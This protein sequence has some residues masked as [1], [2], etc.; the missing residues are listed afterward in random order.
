MP[1]PR[2]LLPR[3]PTL[4]AHLRIHAL[5][6]MQPQGN[7]QRNRFSLGKPFTAA[8]IAGDVSSTRHV[9]PI[10]HD[11]M[12]VLLQPEQFG[13]NLQSRRPSRRWGNGSLS[14]PSSAL[15]VNLP[16]PFFDGAVLRTVPQG[17]SADFLSGIFPTAALYASSAAFC[18]ATSS[19]V[20]GRPEPPNMFKFC[21]LASAV[22]SSMIADATMM[23]LMVASPFLPLNNF[24]RFLFLAAQLFDHARC[25]QNG[26]IGGADVEPGLE[27]RDRR[28]HRQT[29][30]R[31]DLL[32][33][34]I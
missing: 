9:F 34:V 14:G 13:R 26:R 15:T 8:D 4:P 10:L 1:R 27:I 21:E 7:W 28:R 18:F 20:T 17:S 31:L 6:Y 5:V 19:W 30:E 22:S 33:R 3:K 12:P 29:T 11:R 23:L 24:I 32:P 25:A 16:G 2:P